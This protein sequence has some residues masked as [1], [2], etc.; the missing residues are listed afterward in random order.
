[1]FLPINTTQKRKLVQTNIWL[2]R[3]LDDTRGYYIVN[4]GVRHSLYPHVLH[5]GIVA[6]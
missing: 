4:G 6:I 1:M 2:G 5:R 3:A